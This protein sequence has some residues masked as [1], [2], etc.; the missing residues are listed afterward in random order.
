MSGDAIQSHPLTKPCPRPVPGL[1][2]VVGGM[3]VQETLAGHRAQYMAVCLGKGCSS[4]VEEGWLAMGLSNIA[5]YP[6]IWQG[7]RHP[8]SSGCCVLPQPWCWPSLH[9]TSMTIAG[10]A[11]ALAVGTDSAE[12]CRSELCAADNGATWSG[13]HI[14][15][16]CWD[17]GLQDTDRHAPQRWLLC[18]QVLLLVYRMCGGWQETRGRAWGKGSTAGARAKGWGRPKGNQHPEGPCLPC[19]LR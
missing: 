19:P 13:L 15:M 6:S 10:P 3:G 4:A 14:Q 18:Q 9:S 1:V 12:A 2:L 16:P 7:Q 17:G 5:G 11:A 8:F